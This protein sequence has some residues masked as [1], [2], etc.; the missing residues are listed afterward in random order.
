MSCG[1][2]NHSSVNCNLSNKLEYTSI[3]IEEET[4]NTTAHT[5][6]CN[7]N[8]CTCGC[9]CKGWDEKNNKWTF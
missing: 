2:G 1:G 4:L 3:I 8:S 6:L 5:V 9:H 7:E